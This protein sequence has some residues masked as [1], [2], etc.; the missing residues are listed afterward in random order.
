MFKEKDF[1]QIDHWKNDFVMAKPFDISD[2]LQRDNGNTSN[3]D[4]C[5]DYITEGEKEEAK[6]FTVD[7]TQDGCTVSC[8]CHNANFQCQKTK[9]AY[10]PK[11]LFVSRN[12][13]SIT[14]SE[15]NLEDEND[16]VDEQGE[17][18]C[19]VITTNRSAHIDTSTALPPD[20]NFQLNCKILRR[21]MR[22]RYY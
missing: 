20:C 11:V 2:S 18:N 19:V 15:N 5:Y 12:H 21:L 16:C 7:C 1:I 13:T 4:N 14:T 10:N 8:P 22:V 9:M 17:N 3:K 6:I